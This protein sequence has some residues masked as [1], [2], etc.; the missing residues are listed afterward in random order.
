MATTTKLM[1]SR[2]SGMSKAKRE[3]PDVTSVPTRLSSRPSTTIPSALISEPCASTTEAMRP[4]TISEKYSGAWNLRATPASGGARKATT[5]VA[6]VPAKK[7]A[8]AAVASAAPA[9]PCWAMR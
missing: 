2:S 7:E 8:M 9:R 1:P 5:K 4:S 6:T 3:V